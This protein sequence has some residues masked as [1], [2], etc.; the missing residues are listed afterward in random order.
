MRPF[1][2]PGKSHDR[3]LS[4][5]N[6]RIVPTS[7]PF[8]RTLLTYVARFGDLGFA[9]ALFFADTTR[10]PLSNSV[11]ISF[12]TSSGTLIF[13]RRARTKR[14]FHSMSSGVVGRS[15]QSE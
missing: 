7:M 6:Q 13:A 8:D 5:A 12:G 4:A 14:P 1:V 2:R 15:F 11:S 9:G 3:T 10:K